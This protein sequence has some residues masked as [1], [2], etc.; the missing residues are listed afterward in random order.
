M[1]KRGSRYLRY[2]IFNATKYHLEDDPDLTSCS[3]IFRRIK[4]KEINYNSLPL[5]AMT[6][7]NFYGQ[8][9]PLIYKGVKDKTM[10]KHNEPDY[11]LISLEQGE[12]K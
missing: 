5:D 8:G 10:R 3:I 2:A 12:S 9:F 4:D 7:K 1:E 6:L 11:E